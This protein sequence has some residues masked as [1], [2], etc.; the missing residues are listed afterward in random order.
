MANHWSRGYPK[1]RAHSVDSYHPEYFRQLADVA[2]IEN[3]PE[4]LSGIFLEN[5]DTRKRQPISFRKYLYTIVDSKKFLKT[6][7][8]S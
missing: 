5:E 6:F 7:V 8:G 1:H 3:V 4:V 2:D